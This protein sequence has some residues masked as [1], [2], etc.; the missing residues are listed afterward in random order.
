MPENWEKAKDD[1]FFTAMEWAR[2]NRKMP[3]YTPETLARAWEAFKLAL[4]VAEAMKVRML[5]ANIARSRAASPDGKNS[6]ARVEDYRIAHGHLPTQD[7]KPVKG[8][9]KCKQTI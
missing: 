2:L 4:D 5:H 3:G 8:C 7:G 6:W 9:E 1:V